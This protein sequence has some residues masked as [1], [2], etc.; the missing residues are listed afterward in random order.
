MSEMSFLN[1]IEFL[2]NESPT[3]Y[4]VKCE[5]LEFGN[6]FNEPL[7]GY[8][9]TISKYAILRFCHKDRLTNYDYEDFNQPITL[10]ANLRE[11]YFGKHFNQILILS[12]NLISLSLSSYFNMPLFLTTNLM[13]LT[14][15]FSFDQHIFLTK[16]LK[17][18]I[19]EYHFN[20]PL[21]LSKKLLEISLSGTFN[22][23]LILTKKLV[24]V[25]IGFGYNQPLKL[26]KYCVRL[27]IYS[28]CI[29]SLIL[30]K[31]LKEL[32]MS[33]LCEFP[34]IFETKIDKLYISLC[35]NLLLVGHNVD[36]NNNL[37]MKILDNIPN[38]LISKICNFNANK[39]ILNNLPS[40]KY[41]YTNWGALYIENIP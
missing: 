1:E 19:F 21:I 24:N 36:K 3:K 9:E 16:N 32:D 29:Q 14:T 40:D 7:D 39:Y 23:P 15:G 34:I 8:Y 2:S 28:S 22:H 18:I 31:Y 13:M 10:T 11:V 20:K 35:I 33:S 37:Q 12:K 17:S 4:F 6:D 25:K 26:S 41:K 5:T 27:T 38:G 30:T